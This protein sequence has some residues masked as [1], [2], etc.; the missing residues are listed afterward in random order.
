MSKE[1]MKKRAEERDRRRGRGETQGGYDSSSPEHQPRAGGRARPGQGYDVYMGY[2]EYRPGEAASLSQDPVSGASAPH[3]GDAVT[4]TAASPQ[5]QGNIAPG[6]PAL[7]QGHPS[8]EHPPSQG[9]Q[10]EEAHLGQEYQGAGARASPPYQ[11]DADTATVASPQSQGNIVS[12]AL[13]PHQ[14]HPSAG[15]PQSQGYQGAEAHPVVMDT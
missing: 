5:P 3:Q 11:G 4:A 2:P 6:A 10:L 9:Y 13:V 7:H 8:S 12:G 1:R 15:G 14:G